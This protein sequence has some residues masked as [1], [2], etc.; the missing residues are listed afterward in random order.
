VDYLN[1][2]AK[3]FLWEAS[4]TEACLLLHGFTGSPAHMRYL[5][6]Y[7]HQQ[8]GYTVRG[9]LLPGHGTSVEEMAATTHQ[10]WLTAA[11]EEYQQMAEDY[12]QVYVMGLSMG[13]VL[14]L[15]L[16]EE[17]EVDKVIP[18]AAPVKIHDKLAYLSPVLKYFKQYDSWAEPEDQ[19]EYDVGYS[20]MPV[21]CVPELLEL[22]KMMEQNL[23]QVTCPA[24]IVQSYQDETVKP[25]SAEIIEKKIVSSQ[26][27]ILW[28]EESGHVCTVGPEK[29]EI[30]QQVLNF[31]ED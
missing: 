31:L 9:A 24:L 26:P 30:H 27:R 23:G 13:G 28:L 3:P 25:V 29:E 15:L 5:G 4:Q 19:D 14:S 16:A 18:I 12:E 6:E 8:G 7:L 2:Y 10:D 11:E 22:M 1:E 17:Y 21:K 20:K